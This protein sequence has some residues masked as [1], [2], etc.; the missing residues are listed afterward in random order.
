MPISHVGEVLIY[1]SDIFI[2]FASGGLVGKFGFNASS[3]N[4]SIYLG[5]EIKKA[6]N[7]FTEEENIFDGARTFTGANFRSNSY[8]GGGSG[9]I[10]L[11][12]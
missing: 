3:G 5:M 1:G 11:T 9:Y 10:Y 2:E 12:L 7:E 6:P 8:D 4:E